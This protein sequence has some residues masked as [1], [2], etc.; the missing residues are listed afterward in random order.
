MKNIKIM[1][2]QLECISGLAL[3]WLFSSSVLVNNS[4]KVVANAFDFEKNQEEE[5]RN[6]RRSCLIN[7]SFH[8]KKNL[9]RS[10]FL[11]C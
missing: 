5:E 3:G 9:V 11:R 8:R 6:V 2:I 4:V 7:K 10:R 1:L